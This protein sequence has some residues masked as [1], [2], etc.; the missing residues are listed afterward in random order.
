M[1]KKL[2]MVAACVAAV[3]MGSGVAYADDKNP[4]PA[5][6]P[7]PPSGSPLC[8]VMG[9]DD[10]TK[11]ELAPCGWAYGDEKGWYQVP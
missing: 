9:G 8:N 1:T 3:G 2:M 11:W 7:S 5:P 4:A 10:G 6:A